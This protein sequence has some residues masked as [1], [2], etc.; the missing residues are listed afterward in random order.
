MAALNTLR[1]KGSLLLTVVIGLALFAFLIGDGQALLNADGTSVGTINGNEVTTREYSEEV[2]NMTQVRQFMTGQTSLS[3]QETEMIQ[4]QAWGSFINKLSV[5]PAYSSLGIN[6]TEDEMIDLSS[7]DNISP[8]I[9]QF[10]SDQSG[11]F[12]LQFLSNFTSR[13]SNDKQDPANKFW[14]FAKDQARTYRLSEKFTTLVKQGMFVTDLQVEQAYNN[15]KDNY[16]I[17]FITKSVNSIKDEEITVTDS[18]LRAYYEKHKSRFKSGD[19][20]EVEYVTFDI[21]PSASDYE[22]AQMKSVSI[23]KELAESVD[24][25]QYVNYNSEGRF[26]PIYYDLS[27]LPNYLQAVVPN[28]RKG[29]TFEP[30]FE[31][32]QYSIARLNDVKMMPDSLQIRS[33]IIPSSVNVDSVFNVAK[34]SN[35]DLESVIATVAQSSAATSVPT[36]I[37][38]GALPAKYAELL[39]AKSGQTF[40]FNEGQ[41]VHQIVRVTKVGKRVERYQIAEVLF[42][43]VPSNE[44]EQDIYQKAT[45]LINEIAAG[46]SFEDAVNANQYIKRYTPVQT[47]DRDFA[48]IES[49][50]EL[51]RWAFTADAGDV[52]TV[53]SAKDVNIVAYLRAKNTQGIQPFEAVKRD[54][55]T[56]YMAKA[57]M[58]KVVAEL[59][60]AQSLE[61]LADKLNVDVN[62]AVDVNFS[63]FSI[64]G[65]GMAPEVI[66]NMTVLSEGAISK[67]I[68]A[69]NTAA[70]IKITNKGAKDGF[71]MDK[72]RAL[73]AS[74]IETY[75]ES[76]ISS[77]LES[78]VEISDFR[79]VYY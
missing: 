44:T 16:S 15:G 3:T 30:N 2:E 59:S 78:M 57:K 12:N 61:S 13:L 17:E 67:G 72:A 68:P 14:A 58:D 66:G 55:S 49:S 9:R 24:A 21:V 54:V 63:D 31:G 47:T 40:L 46:K 76:R 4:D 74:Q 53:V 35:S 29:A 1:T 41:G 25:E 43:V 51:V 8:V 6:V 69:G 60:N 7:G 23:A 20:S 77:T 10:F 45:N 42:A 27:A 73:V 11:V 36:M 65:I 39:T 62:S 18:D 34:K 64:P 79:V 32:D 56:L 75:I 52:S 37:N 71:N 5:V 38:T 26:D 28:A 50:R 48:S 70:V 22:A 19:M 33:V